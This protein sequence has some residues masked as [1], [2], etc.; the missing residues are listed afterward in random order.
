MHFSF[1]FE[2]IFMNG[3]TSAQVHNDNNINKKANHP[4]KAQINQK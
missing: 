4:R 1:L 2:A 3:N